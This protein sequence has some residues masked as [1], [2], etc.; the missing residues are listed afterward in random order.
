MAALASRCGLR[1]IKMTMRRCGALRRQCW[2]LPRKRPERQSSSRNSADTIVHAFFQAATL[3]LISITVILFLA[4]RRVGDVLVTLVPLLLA[5][6]VTLEL[7][8]LFGLPLNF[9]NIIALPLLLGVGVA[10]KIYYV[11]AWREGETSLLASSLTRAVLFSAMTT[12]TAFA[13]L[14]LS[15]HPGTSSMGKLL[16]LSLVTTLAAAV[17]FQ[18]ILMG[19]PRQATE[20]DENREPSPLPPHQ[21]PGKRR[22]ELKGSGQAASSRRSRRKRKNSTPFPQASLHH[23]RAPH[24]LA[25]DGGDF[26]RAEVEP[27]IKRIDA[28]ENLGVAEMRIRQGRDLRA[29]LGQQFLILVMQPIVL[30]RLVVQEGA[31]IGCSE[32]HLDRVWVDLLGEADGLLDGLLGLA[33]QS[34]DETCR[35]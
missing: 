27:S 25:D 20:Q 23:L 34:E 8:V 13:S 1:A 35:E 17:L 31:W 2:P 19:P 11:L 9:A 21:Q 6:V 22:S 29:K 32:R 33:G 24:H 18:P 15:H 3:A 16:S 4:L 10:F 12:A 5:G 7:T 28:V 30:A 26:R 14:W